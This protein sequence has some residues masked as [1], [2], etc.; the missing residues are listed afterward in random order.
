MQASQNRIPRPRDADH[1]A[2]TQRSAQV[3]REPEHP[4]GQPLGTNPR[5]RPPLALD[6]DPNTS[7]KLQKGCPPSPGRR[8]VSTIA[9][10]KRGALTDVQPPRGRRAARLSTTRRSPSGNPRF[11][12]KLP[13]LYAQVPAPPR[14]AMAY[15]R[16]PDGPRGRMVTG[17]RQL[18][19]RPLRT[20]TLRHFCCKYHRAQSSRDGAPL[21]CSYR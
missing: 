2:T 1:A 14:P 6:R 18:E 12:P 5:H 20:T 21:Q 15:E 9:R 3:P 17:N 8:E 13:A 7:T 11:A 4:R 19:G 16:E 10:A